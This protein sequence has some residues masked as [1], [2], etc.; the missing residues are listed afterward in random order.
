MIASINLPSYLCISHRTVFP[1]TS[2]RLFL[3]RS[4]K[5]SL[6]L[7][8]MLLQAQT[9]LNVTGHLWLHPVLI[10]AGQ[11]KCEGSQWQDKNQC[12][13]PVWLSQT[14]PRTSPS[15]G[16]LSA[17]LPNSKVKEQNTR[18]HFLSVIIFLYNLLKLLFCKDMRC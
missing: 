5:N 17:L 3:C 4:L 2:R 15:L 14:K 8:T 1:S 11:L 12:Q 10:I 18:T 7:T 13:L 16:L 6:P 9:P